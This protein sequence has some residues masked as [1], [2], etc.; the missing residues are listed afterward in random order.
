MKYVIMYAV[1][2]IIVATVDY[3]LQKVN[4]H[5]TLINDLINTQTLKK[6]AMHG[7]LFP[8]YIPIVIFVAMLVFLISVVETV[9]GRK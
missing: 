1:I 8:L 4:T 5:S 3:L 7:V 9:Q 6:A 2:A